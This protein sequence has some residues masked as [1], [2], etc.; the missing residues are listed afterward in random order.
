VHWL[1]IG[2]QDVIHIGQA[3]YSDHQN[4]YLANREGGGAAPD[5]GANDHVCFN[6]AGIQEF[7][8]RFEAAGVDFSE[9]QAHDQALF[10]LFV[11]DPINGIKIEP[12]F[13]AEESKRAGR[14]PTRIGSAR[15]DSLRPIAERAPRG[16]GRAGHGF[17]RSHGPSKPLVNGDWL[18]L[19]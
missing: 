7:V 15:H 12:N 16:P 13:A 19:G 4:R 18:M 14:K 8:R 1:Y 11:R 17:P 6:C 10:Q 9:P 3:N 5:T 2:D